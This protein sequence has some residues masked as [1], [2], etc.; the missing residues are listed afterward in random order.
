M[1][2]SIAERTF[3]SI[4]GSPA[5]GGGRD[6]PA[7]KRPLRKAAKS[8]QRELFERR[9]A[10]LKARIPVGGLREATIRALLYVGMT[11]AAVD[12][13][14]FELARRIRQAN[15]SLPLPNSRRS[16]ASSSACC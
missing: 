5:A 16:S 1:S 15:D 7:G 8:L 4:Y 9:I 2:E 13:R 10:E 14:G 12:E 6:R 11:R 3:L